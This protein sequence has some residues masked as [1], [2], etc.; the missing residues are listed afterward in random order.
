MQFYEYSK[1]RESIVE[2]ARKGSS[3][4]KAAKDAEALVGRVAL[5]QDNPLNGYKTTNHGETRINNCIKYDLCGRS[6]LVTVQSNGKCFLLF[7]GD[8]NTVDKWLDA[9]K[10][11]TFAL[12]DSQKLVEITSLSSVIGDDGP[13][14]IENRYRHS[15]CLFELLDEELF[16]RFFDGMPRAIQ[17]RLEKLTYLDELDLYNIAE[18]LE[19]DYK[20]AVLDTFLSLIAGDLANSVRVI[21]LYLG[22]IKPVEEI[23]IDSII[24][25]SEFLKKISTDSPQYPAL[26]RNF[27]ENSEYKEWM[28][29]MHPD[30][31]SVAF[32]DFS[33]PSK[34]LGVSGSGKTCV[35]IQRAIYLAKKYPC[36][37]ILVVTL[38]KPLALLI[39]SLVIQL[40]EPEL[41]QQIE[42]KPFFAV[43]QELLKEFEPD[44][45]KLYEDTTWKSGEHIDVIW[46]EF[47]RCEL[48]N[49]DAA[50]L[51]Y[52]HDSLISRGID[53]EQYIREEFDWIRSAFSVNN[54]NGYLSILRQGR[55]IPLNER[56]RKLLLQGLI[57]WE[58]K[59][60]DI[61]VTD[62][63]NIST[64]VYKYIDKIPS[65]Y[66]SILIDESQDFGN[67]E[68]TIAR[69]LVNQNENDIFLCGDAA[70]KISTKYQNLKEAG[71][72]L[73]GSRSKKIVRNYR[74]SREILEL[75]NHILIENLTEEM[76]SSDDFEILD[77]EYASFSDANPLLLKAK[78]LA[79]EISSAINYLNSNI[80]KNQKA[81]ICI[82]GF[83][84]HEI[85][86][87]ANEIGFPV[88]S[89]N[90]DIDNA[91]V[92]LSDLDQTKG[93]E[94]D[95]VCILNCTA[96]VIPAVH[97][98]TEEHFR[99]LS[100][101]YVAMTRAKL[102][103]LI[104]Y[105]GKKSHLFENIE[106]FIIE[107]DWLTFAD[108]TMKFYKQPNKMAEIVHEEDNVLVNLSEMTG[109]LF[110]YR[111]EAI[112]LSNELIAFLRKK[113]NGQGRK[114]KLA[115]GS[116]QITSWKNMADLINDVNN[117][118]AYEHKISQKFIVE[119]N[120][121]KII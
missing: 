67:I 17:R 33:G 89:G 101:L 78:N 22:D 34:L 9:K 30:Q 46:R 45:I 112:G 75:A 114:I 44:N 86:L 2:L 50:I 24:V 1:F 3:Y 59:M 11:M 71:I 56:Q 47:Y 95:Y 31:E 32:N 4:S 49:N 70:Q 85:E 82:A 84:H 21:K 7:A 72:D 37:T 93:F 96:G 66:R 51:Q 29:Y 99:E 109:E 100:R 115:S 77:P 8:H 40:A 10:G 118:N 116:F 68:F 27:A 106:D 52:L 74:N 110:L 14:V 48:R 54:R 113:V 64:A 61:G 76:I 92:F 98:P 38:N 57:A 15:Q 108:K 43:G 117:R 20:T 111:K 120:Q 28:L 23:D 97:L 60:K 19:A 94:F 88:L 42:V 12:D 62:Y 73:H 18:N 41:L 87:Y 53:A 91:S 13:L 103:L 119:L 65:K 104:S 90:V 5:Q 83:S 107:D 63:L 6:R 105:S 102:E 26:L 69:K 36:E 81:C 16:D 58:R 79:V 80:K 55:T 39:E 35:V 25:D 121:L